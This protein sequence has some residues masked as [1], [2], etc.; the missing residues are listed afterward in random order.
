MP[1]ILLL[2]PEW[3]ASLP[4]PPPNSMCPWTWAC[5][6][7]LKSPSLGEDGLCGQGTEMDSKNIA[8]WSAR[9]M[10]AQLVKTLVTQE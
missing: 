9:E 2:D 6:L 7:H 10:I 5:S 1:D 3:V 8:I 4:S